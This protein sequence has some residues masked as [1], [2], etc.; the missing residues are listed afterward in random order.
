MGQ[1]NS[2]TVEQCISMQIFPLVVLTALSYLAIVNS[3]ATI[4]SIVVRV[5]PNSW[6]LFDKSN[7][8]GRS[9]SSYSAGRSGD[10]TR[11][12]RNSSTANSNSYGRKSSSDRPSANR[13]RDSRS[14]GGRSR[15][16][17]K[18]EDGD[19]NYNKDRQ[20][21]AVQKSGSVGRSVAKDAVS[22]KSDP[23]IENVMDL[24]KLGEQERLQKVIARAGI[25]SRREAERMVSRS[26]S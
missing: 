1:L 8:N 11:R 25:A 5:R 23:E 22:S 4:N 13:S 2:G 15:S 26:S 12:S 17:Q 21:A 18:R 19:D 14:G 10:D 3:Y 16:V 20:Q 24:V 6:K 9:R 7:G